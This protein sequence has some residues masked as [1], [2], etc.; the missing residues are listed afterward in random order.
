M[1]KVALAAIAVMLV[2]GWGSAFTCEYP[3]DPGCPPD[4]FYGYIGLFADADHMY[5]CATGVGFYPIEMWIW[6]KPGPLGQICAEFMICGPTNVIPSTVTWNIPLISVMLGDLDIGLSVCYVAC[7]HEWHW[8][9]HRAYWVTD[10][11]KTMMQICPH[12]DTGVYS[13]A[14]CEPGY[15]MEPCTVYTNLYLNAAPPD[16]EC[17]GTATKDASWGAIKSMIE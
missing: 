12:P 6:C 4:G 2:I 5:W 1:K 11:S 7:Q 15:P 3:E 10:P 9:A 17:M 16:P 13:F 14:N 8:I